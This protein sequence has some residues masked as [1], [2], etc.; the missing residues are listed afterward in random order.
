MYKRDG[1][2]A[3][4]VTTA[5]ASPSSLATAEEK[6]PIIAEVRSRSLALGLFG[7][8]AWLS[9]RFCWC[10]SD[11]LIIPG[12]SLATSARFLKID[13]NELNPKSSRNVLAPLVWTDMVVLLL[14]GTVKL[15]SVPPGRGRVVTGE[16]ADAVEDP[17]TATLELVDGTAD[18][19]VDNRD[20]VET[21]MAEVVE[22]KDD[23]GEDE[24]TLARE[25]VV[26]PSVLPELGP[27][28]GAGASSGEEFPSHVL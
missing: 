27:A 3:V 13:S 14:S 9:S 28:L 26:P 6:K 16:T 25:D 4:K 1:A 15:P 21:G 7:S 24:V 11:C 2:V 12:L 20:V 23:K 18:R 17:S 5:R 8:Q 10:G 22:G 19:T